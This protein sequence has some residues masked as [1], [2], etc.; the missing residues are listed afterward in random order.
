MGRVAPLVV[1]Q[2]RSLMEFEVRENL[3]W[4]WMTMTG[5][6]LNCM[7]CWKSNQNVTFPTSDKV[8][9]C[10]FQPSFEFVFKIQRKKIK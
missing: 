7:I 5:D 10:A 1:D 2:F 3:S 4:D 8:V 6:T 9:L